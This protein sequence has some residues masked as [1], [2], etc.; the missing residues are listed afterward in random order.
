MTGGSGDSRK[1][2]FTWWRTSVAGAV[3]ISGLALA[4]SGPPQPK[5][6]A[7]PPAAAA[8]GSTPTVSP[9][10]LVPVSRGL[11]FLDHSALAA[12][13]QVPTAGAAHATAT[14][15]VAVLNDNPGDA[16]PGIAVV[17]Q[18]VNDARVVA[19]EAEIERPIVLAP[20]R[21]GVVRVLVRLATRQPGEFGG[22]IVLT[23]RTTSGS[24]DVRPVRISVSAPRPKE[25]PKATPPRS[26]AAVDWVLRVGAA[27]ALAV[28]VA[29]VACA[30]DR[31]VHGGPPTAVMRGEVSGVTW[32]PRQSWATN[33]AAA[34]ALLAAIT[35]LVSSRSTLG[36]MAPAEY[37]ALA[38]LLTGILAVAPLLSGFF[39][40]APA[41]AGG[42]PA[43]PM[44][45]FLVAGWFT[46]T[47][48]YSQLLATVLLTG[49]AARLAV[50]SPGGRCLAYGALLMVAAGLTWHALRNLVGAV[51]QPDAA[52]GDDRP[53][54]P[55]GK[56][57]EAGG[58]LD[59]SVHLPSAPTSRRRGMGSRGGATAPRVAPSPQVPARRPLL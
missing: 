23:E 30:R 6:A 11:R 36:Y 25:P 32:E 18:A 45:V 20:Q 38:A 7:P 58:E 49:D 16:R 10:R 47:A 9:P 22:S 52:P 39:Q 40:S 33:L 48:A 19:A 57:D 54:R 21:A 28:V 44:V 34:G 8:Q 37:G 14:F 4:L 51:A 1:A 35:P 2:G 26:S 5:D 53:E 31:A 55:L 12:T 46:L 41:A 29:A 50:L 17:M 42:A 59:G 15:E 43:V 27:A 13:V 56:D 3:G 24:A